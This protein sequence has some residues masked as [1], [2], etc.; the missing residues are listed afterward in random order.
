MILPV[1]ELTAFPRCSVYEQL[2]AE[3][4]SS[5][6]RPLSVPA[7]L[8]DSRWQSD[9]VIGSGG[10]LGTAALEFLDRCLFQRYRELILVHSLSDSRRFIRGS[11]LTKTDCLSLREVAHTE[12]AI[13]VFQTTVKL[14]TGARSLVDLLSVG[15]KLSGLTTNLTLIPVTRCATVF[16]P[17][18]FWLSLRLQ[19]MRSSDGGKKG[20]GVVRTK[21]SRLQ[22]RGRRVPLT[23]Q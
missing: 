20:G 9:S 7:L 8:D 13:F 22:T 23:L 14:L 11:P 17:A 16:V 6:Q 10:L 19:P 5:A 15:A 1:R 3:E 12:C 21:R 2:K 18:T 4:C